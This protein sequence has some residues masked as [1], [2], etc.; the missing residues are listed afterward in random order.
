MVWKRES[1]CSARASSPLVKREH[2]KKMTI[3]IIFLLAY[4]SRKKI[5]L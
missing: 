1:L 5:D 3:K 4:I 2:N